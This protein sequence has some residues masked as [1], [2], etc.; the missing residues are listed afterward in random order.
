MTDLIAE[1]TAT[2][3]AIDEATKGIETYMD[4]ASKQPPRA[5][6]VPASAP[7]VM[8]AD[9][10]GFDP[11]P[12]Q[13]TLPPDTGSY[14]SLPAPSDL[15]QPYSSDPHTSEPAPE[16]E[17]VP[18]PAP[19]PAPA[20]YSMPE[21]SSRAGPPPTSMNYYH[22]QPQQHYGNPNSHK[23]VESTASAFGDDFIMGAGGGMFS[24]APADNHDDDD[25]DHMIMGSPSLSTIKSVPEINELK[26]KA[27]E[28]EDVARDAQENS[29]QKMAQVNE[30]RRLADEAN[31]E[32]R[33]FADTGKDEKKKKGF[34][35]RNKKAIKKDVKEAER[36]AA[37]AKEK[38]EKLMAAQAEANDAQA[39]AMET[40]RE[41][42]KLRQEVEDAEIA[43]ASAASMQETNPVPAPPQSN[44]YNPGSAE[45]PSY[46]KP[47][48]NPYYG[49]GSNGPPPS[50]GYG[51]PPQPPQQ[52]QPSGG[53]QQFG[54][55]GYNPTVMGSGGGMS[56]PTPT[57]DAYDNPFGE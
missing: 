20:P 55:Y 17:S 27:K 6:P 8:E 15:S 11:P 46:G 43:A 28:A 54:G 35:G 33:R 48:P 24:A 32:A 18:E 31:A 9:L 44:G 40:K 10:F 42:E 56:I 51:Q 4:E 34:M 16:P 22:Q 12:G 38:Q 25:H 47:P 39:F 14:D 7:V 3:Q 50:Y 26:M 36:V 29:R 21:P 57:G 30:L 52:Q 2:K 1:A 41:A 53:Q 45:P 19:E 49:G 5:A 23:R 37:D 13:G